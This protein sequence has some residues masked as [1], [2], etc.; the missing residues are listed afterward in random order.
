MTDRASTSDIRNEGIIA[1]LRYRMTSEEQ[2]WPRFAPVMRAVRDVPI[3]ELRVHPDLCELLWT[4]APD[5]AADDRRMFMGAAVLVSDSHLIYALAYSQSFLAVRLP[6]NARTDLI[7][8]LGGDAQV[9][10]AW[11]AASLQP[12]ARIA[13][14]G[15][16]W[17]VV[18]PCFT[19]PRASLRAALSA[20]REAACAETP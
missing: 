11:A 17:L 15:N 8:S 18:D 19:P 7:G 10:A 3:G 14:L 5:D 16:D 4:L 13:T 1:F 6:D 12:R 2:Q 20:S 9:I